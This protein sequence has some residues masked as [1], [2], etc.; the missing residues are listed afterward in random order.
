[1]YY[2]NKL[3]RNIDVVYHIRLL[4]DIS[5][6][7]CVCTSLSNSHIDNNLKLETFNWQHYDNCQNKQTKKTEKT[8]KTK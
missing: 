1:M 3:H 2:T 5:K 8:L 7:I 4:C 6:R